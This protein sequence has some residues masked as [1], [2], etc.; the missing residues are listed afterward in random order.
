[1]CY[2]RSYALCAGCMLRSPLAV[3]DP[4]IVHSVLLFAHWTVCWRF[5]CSFKFAIWCF[6]APLCS[7]T[8]E[9]GAIEARG[10]FD[11]ESMAGR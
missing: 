10:E 11:R 8:R 1:M 3:D 5:D 4:S 9:Y 7:T 6:V 2:A